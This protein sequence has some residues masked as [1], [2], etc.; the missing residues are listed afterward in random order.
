MLDSYRLD[1]MYANKIKKLY[2]ISVAL[3]RM[4]LALLGNIIIYRRSTYCPRLFEHV[5]I[6]ASGK[7]YIC[8]HYR[9][10]SFGNINKKKLLDI[11]QNSIRLK[12]FRWMSLHRFLFCYFDC[13]LLSKKEKTFNYFDKMVNI[14]PHLLKIEYGYSCNLACIM[15][16]QNHDSLEM[17]DINVFKNNVDWSKVENIELQG[18]E[19]LY[20]PGA[21]ELY[22][23]LTERLDKKLDVISN[24]TLLNELW[25][26][27]FVKGSK[28]IK[29]SVNA[30]SKA[31]YDLINRASNFDRVIENIKLLVSFKKKYKNQCQIIF[32]HT[33]IAENF[34]EMPDSIILADSLGCDEVS[35]CFTSSVKDFLFK[36]NKLVEAVKARLVNLLD[37]DIKVKVSNSVNMLWEIVL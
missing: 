28:S 25:A 11:W 30:A 6:K 31:V 32:H 5:F 1:G 14:Y 26:E 7:V 8:C 12:L 23:W 4:I 22:V 18:G 16:E 9:P 17:T 2:T 3:T 15:C 35:F 34:H 37:S 36:N 10:I 33:V 24:G 13:G 27:K 29:I 19:I 20:M 21:K